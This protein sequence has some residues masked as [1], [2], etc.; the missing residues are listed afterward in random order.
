MKSVLKKTLSILVF[1]LVLLGG[2]V[3]LYRIFSWK[4]T[5]GDYFSSVNQAYSLNDHIVD[6]AFF[7]PSVTY[8][9][10][11]PAIFWEQEGISSFNAAVS[12]QDRNASIYYV[13]EFLKRQ[14]PKLI[15]LSSSY[16]YTDY[17]AVQGNLYRNA[18]SLAP[19]IN[20]LQMQRK[21]VPNNTLPTEQRLLDY[22]LRWPIVHSR[23]RE[24][25]KGDFVSVNGND[26][27]LGFV[28]DY[29]TWYQESFSEYAT[30]LSDSIPI[31]PQVMQWINDLKALGDE[32][33]FTLLF[34]T[35]P[36]DFYPG[37]RYVINGCYEYLDEIGIPHLDLNQAL[38][39]MEFVIP[40]DMVDAIHANITGATKISAFV[41]SY[42]AEHYDLPDHRS[43]KGYEIYEQCLASYR[44]HLFERNE[45]PYLDSIDYVGV[46]AEDP[47]LLYSV[48]V[49]PESE[50]AQ[51]IMDLLSE[52]GV[53][54]AQILTGGTWILKGKK[55]L[56]SPKNQSYGYQVNKSDFLSVTP[57]LSP[58][59]L[60]TVSVGQ[61]T[62][63]T[64]E[65]GNCCIVTYDLVLDR[66]IDVHEFY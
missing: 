9:S 31:D 33:G 13:K 63:V 37:E 30:D 12:G 45:L 36:S 8:S 61:E 57:D 32:N 15:L 23:Y 55:V 6:V 59:R 49:R 46:L 3:L 25:N 28:Y 39:E 38:A 47:S 16:F 2:L 64:P 52:A 48:S 50:I 17:Y 41:A 19:S 7:G 20:S 11:N 21:V 29:D 62:F 51:E 35:T 44:H 43:D 58:K 42:L 1:L 5:S 27:C 24:L 34:V 18:L 65:N 22:Y 4:D 26:A 10:Y 60:D 66:V 54:E 56:C 40:L 14:S 53:P